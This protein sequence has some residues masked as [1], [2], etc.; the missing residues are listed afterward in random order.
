MDSP[1]THHGSQAEQGGLIARRQSRSPSPVAMLTRLEALR[2]GRLCCPCRH[3]SYGL[4]RLPLGAP[5]L[6]RITAYRFRRYRAPQVGS[7]R[8]SR[9]CRD[10]S[11]LFHDRLCN[12]SAPYTPAGSWALL[13]QG[14]HAFHGLRPRSTGSAPAWFLLPQGGL[15]TLQGSSSYGPVACSP[16]SEYF[17][18]A[19]RRSG[20]PFRRPSATGPLG[21][22]PGRTS[23]G[24]SITASH[25][26]H[27]R[28]PR[29]RC[30]CTEQGL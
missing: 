30:S 19:L 3:R 11:L 18:M 21:R 17:V 25:D 5:P 1:S 10:G 15:T 4:L 8:P 27:Y 22:Y 7:L 6:R 2:S 28:N 24:K 12:R 16:P 9:R 26:T 20:L 14:L 23:T 13:F 29:R